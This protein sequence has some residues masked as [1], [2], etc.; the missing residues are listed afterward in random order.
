MKKCSIVENDRIHAPP[1]LYPRRHDNNV[2]CE[3]NEGDESKASHGH[4]AFIVGLETR[5]SALQL[6]HSEKQGMNDSLHG[7]YVNSSVTVYRVAKYHSAFTLEQRLVHRQAQGDHTNENQGSTT[8]RWNIA[9][10]HQDP[11]TSRAPS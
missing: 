8:P 2:G 6:H 1:S 3:M 10:G 4:R 11:A 7:L 5:T 9:S